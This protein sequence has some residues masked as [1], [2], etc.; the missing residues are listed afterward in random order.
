M[1]ALSTRVCLCLAPLQ[2]LTPLVATHQTG[3]MSGR[4]VGDTLRAIYQSEGPRGF[5]RCQLQRPAGAPVPHGVRQRML[6]V[7][8][9]RC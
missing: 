3:R 5:F 8:G 7:A 2:A 1:I 9:S 6:P 4:G